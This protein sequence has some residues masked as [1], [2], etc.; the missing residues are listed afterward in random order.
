MS[1]FNLASS[2]YNA[3]M[4]LI[5]NHLCCYPAMTV[6]DI[7][8]LLYQ[9]VLGP[10]HIMPSADIFTARLKDELAGLQ[11]DPSE[12]LLEPI[13][14]DGALQRISL[15]AWLANGQELSWLVQACLET[16]Q[17]AW[18]T[19]AELGC[20]WRWFLDQVEE[21][22]FPSI[23]IREA[24]ALDNW[25]QEDDFPAAHHSTAYVTAYRPAY[26][27]VGYFI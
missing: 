24:K 21:G 5:Q 2:N 18:G 17:R 10:E 6:R 19:K 8:K 12:L 22:Q 3:W 4:E 11:P 7:Y 20:I 13:R 9:G 15:R 26:R 23:E 1:Q 14:P 25:L 16:G 27:L